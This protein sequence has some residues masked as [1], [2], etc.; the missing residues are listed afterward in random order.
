MELANPAQDAGR[1]RNVKGPS[2]MG[3]IPLQKPCTSALPTPMQLN[4]QLAMRAQD[5]TCRAVTKGAFAGCS[6][7]NLMTKESLLMFKVPLLT[8]DQAVLTSNSHV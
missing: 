7:R 4:T 6:K 3:I 2:L 8:I 5:N 1:Q